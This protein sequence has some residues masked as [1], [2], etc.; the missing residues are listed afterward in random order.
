VLSL[1]CVENES[2]FS[3]CCGSSS[4]DASS[5]IYRSTLSSCGIAIYKYRVFEVQN[6]RSN[7]IPHERWESQ[8]L[9]IGKDQGYEDALQLRALQGMQECF[10]A[11]TL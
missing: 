1:A 6:I 5:A 2:L 11:A 4:F 9:S 8:H 3:Y 7:R 10:A